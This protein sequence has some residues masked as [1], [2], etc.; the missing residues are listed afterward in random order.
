ML[1]MRGILAVL[2]ALRL[3]CVSLAVLSP[4]TWASSGSLSV[5]CGPLVFQ[6]RRSC[7]GLDLW[8]GLRL[9]ALTCRPRRRAERDRRYG[10]VV[11]RSSGMFGC[12]G[13]IHHWRRPSRLGRVQLWHRPGCFGPLQLWHIPRPLQEDSALAQIGPLQETFD[14]S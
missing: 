4:L 10:H 7:C 2:L 1:V 8:Q 3:V 14:F 11:L 6:L 9:A 12:F 13:R 5:T